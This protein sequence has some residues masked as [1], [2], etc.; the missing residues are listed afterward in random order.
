MQR[1][2]LGG[3]FV[4]SK[5]W[6]SKLIYLEAFE[7]YCGYLACTEKHPREVNYASFIQRAMDETRP[8]AVC[9]SEDGT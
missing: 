1:V 5:T 8:V 2:V 3:A 6:L 7:R 9:L 4:V